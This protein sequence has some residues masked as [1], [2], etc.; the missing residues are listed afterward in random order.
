MLYFTNSYPFGLGEQWKTNELKEL[1]KYFD[2]IVVL[3]FSYG[4]NK[5]KTQDIPTNIQILD[6][7]FETDSFFL[8]KVDYFKIIFNK[9]CLKFINE[10]FIK[11]VYKKKARFV[12]WAIACK[13][14]TRLVNHLTLKQLLQQSNA[15]TVWYFFWGKGTA[16]ILPFVT[17]QSKKNIVVKLHGYD[18]YEE[19]YNGYFP[20]RDLLFQKV[21]NILPISDDGVKYLLAKHPQISNKIILNRLGTQSDGS[22]SKPSSDG[23]FRVVSCSGLVELKRVHLMIAAL[24]YIK[25][26]IQWIHIGDGEQREQLENLVKAL[27]VQHLF[28]FEGFKK[29]SEVKIFYLSQ[30]CDLFVNTSRT[31]GVPI[32]IMEAFSVGIPVLATNVG[33]TSEIVD[34]TVGGLMPENITPQELANCITKFIELNVDVRTSYRQNAYQKFTTMCDAKYWANELGKILTHKG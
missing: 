20:F 33:G 30:S 18:L 1:V 29:P 32:S 9:N 12:T 6:P 11:Q 21:D 34:E 25:V 17:I 23:V 7:L 8:K 15:E 3:P 28:H 31:E 5:I 27:D 14:A 19:I 16:E 24:P 13:Q 10:F 4:G 2:E 26:P 22:L